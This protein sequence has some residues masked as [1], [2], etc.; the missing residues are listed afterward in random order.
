M[1]TIVDRARPEIRRTAKPPWFAT[2][3]AITNDVGEVR[4]RCERRE[5]SDD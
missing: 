2:I 5:C 1:R 3:E 4:E